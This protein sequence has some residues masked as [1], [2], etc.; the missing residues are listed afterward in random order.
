[1]NKLTSEYILVMEL[2]KHDGSVLN[3]LRLQALVAEGFTHWE[4]Y[5]ILCREY[6]N[7]LK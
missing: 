5:M 1:M 6:V 3:M 4:A 2:M 7:E